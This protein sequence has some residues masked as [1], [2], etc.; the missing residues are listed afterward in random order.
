MKNYLNKN[1][2]A[3]AGF[4]LVEV[5]ISIF[6]F[7]LLLIVVSSIF[8]QTLKLQRRGFA[9]QKV[10]ENSLFIL[11]TMAKEIRVSRVANQNA[12]DLTQLTITHPQQGT[13]I[14]TFV[15]ASGTVQKTI[16]GQTFTISSSSVIFRRLSFCV[17]GS[18]ASDGLQPRVTVIARVED[19]K[20]DLPIPFD[21][22]T[23]ISS[24][25]HSDE[26]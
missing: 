4:S 16:G 19:T 5:I 6:V 18:G 7:S 11:E 21:L 20:G 3:Q 10:Q 1:K 8:V 26:L 15:G 23:T 17:V 13:I 25:E 22:Q 12:C 9:A 14:Y 2:G 24:R